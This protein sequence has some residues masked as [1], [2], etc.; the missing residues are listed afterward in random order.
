MLREFGTAQYETVMNW[1]YRL[2]VRG[3][4]IERQRVAAAQVMRLRLQAVADGMEQGKKYVPG[5]KDPPPDPN[6]AR[7]DLTPYIK[8]VE[9]LERVAY[10]W[11]YTLEKLIARRIAEEDADFEKFERELGRL[12]A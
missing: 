2:I 5:S 10:P 9:S 6:S 3:I 7:Y 8:T 11:K 4:Q 1:P 12:Q